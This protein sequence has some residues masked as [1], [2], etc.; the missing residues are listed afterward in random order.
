MPSIQ[1][2]VNPPSKPSINEWFKYIHKKTANT[3][4]PGGIAYSELPELERIKRQLRIK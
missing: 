2:T 1:S 3:V 4:K